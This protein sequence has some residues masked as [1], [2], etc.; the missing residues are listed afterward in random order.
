MVLEPD[1]VRDALLYLEEQLIF[2]DFDEHVPHIHR[3]INPSEV[4]YSENLKKY[5][6][7]DVAYAL[8]KLYEAGYITSGTKPHRDH[9]GNIDY[10]CIDDISSDGHELVNSIKKRYDMGYR[11]EKGFSARDFFHR[12]YCFCRERCCCRNNERSKCYNIYGR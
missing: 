12:D 3:R 8:E 10:Y 5:H 1:I 9:L 7:A 4:I 6:P 2:E 11:K